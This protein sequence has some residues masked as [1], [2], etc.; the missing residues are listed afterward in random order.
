MLGFSWDPSY[1][2]VCW[3]LFGQFPGPGVKELQLMLA[4]GWLRCN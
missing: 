3:K 4:S 1:R 2:D